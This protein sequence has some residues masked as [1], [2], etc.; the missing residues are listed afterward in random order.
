MGKGLT[1]GGSAAV[2]LGAFLIWNSEASA[3]QQGLQGQY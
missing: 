1:Y 2:V 3:Q